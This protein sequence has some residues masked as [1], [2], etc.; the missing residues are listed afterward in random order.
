MTNE[1]LLDLLKCS[2]DDIKK[3]CYYTI[4]YLLEKIEMLEKKIETNRKFY[5]SSI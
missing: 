1:K 4:Q 2:D 5:K 3:E